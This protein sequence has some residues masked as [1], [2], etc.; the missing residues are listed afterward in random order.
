MVKVKIKFYLRDMDMVKTKID[1]LDFCSQD[2]EGNYIYPMEIDGE[3]KE[4]K[5]KDPATFVEIL[6]Q[7]ILA[8]MDTYH[9]AKANGEKV[10]DAI[11]AFGDTIVPIEAVNAV[12][13]KLVNE[14]DYSDEDIVTVEQL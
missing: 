8:T 13:V 5:F 10:Q 7:G 6:Y 1:I 9:T 4:A 14:E 12:K 11:F 3:Q 2:T